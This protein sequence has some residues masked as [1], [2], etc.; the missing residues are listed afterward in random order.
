[1]TMNPPLD[2]LRIV[3]STTVNF[4]VHQGKQFVQVTW[5][6]TT[7]VVRC[8]STHAPLTQRQTT[9]VSISSTRESAQVSASFVASLE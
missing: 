1:M 6:P 2:A 5:A 8:L 3:R 4:A 7:I 9:A